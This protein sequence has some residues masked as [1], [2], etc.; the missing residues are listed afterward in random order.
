MMNHT[1]ETREHVTRFGAQRTIKTVPKPLV[2]A[3]A[4]LAALII[5][6]I[7]T[8]PLSTAAHADFQAGM[9]A[10]EKGDYETALKEW[11]PLA[12][13]GDAEAQHNLA[14]IHELGLSTRSNLEEAA[15]LYE[16]AAHNGIVQSQV[17]L[18]VMLIEGRGVI[19]DT[20]RALELMTMAADRGNL[21][22]LHNLANMYYGGIG[23]PVDKY[24]AADFLLRASLKGYA[25][26]QYDLGLTLHRG[27]GIKADDMLALSLLILASETKD[28]S[29]KTKTLKSIDLAM[30]E[31]PENTIAEAKALAISCLHS[32][33][34]DCSIRIR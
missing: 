8:L 11:E 28:P 29:L 18:A 7:T 25:P 17:N 32:A 26:S 21:P 10:Y 24:R 33:Y 31:L 6:V 16:I 3:L 22:A 13:A 30:S 15:S 1:Q 12:K 2:A 34:Q 9:E 23:T 14:I 4:L 5:T 20:P 19:S 27:D